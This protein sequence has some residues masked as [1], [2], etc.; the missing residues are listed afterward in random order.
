MVMITVAAMIVG[1]SG[2]VSRPDL[3]DRAEEI[4]DVLAPMPGVEKVETDY[5]VSD[6]GRTLRY[7]VTMTAEATDDEAA[8]LAS[9]LNSEVGPEFEDYNHEL[10]MMMS[11]FTLELPIET[12]AD[13]LRQQMP[14]LRVLA[15][16]LAASEVLWRE[17]P[18]NDNIED[19]LEIKSLSGNPFDAFSAVRDQFGTDAMSLRLEQT[20]KAM[21]YVKFPYSVPAQD[22]LEAALGSGLKE[23]DQIIVDSDQLTSVSAIVSEGPKVVSRLR[24]IIDLVNSSTSDPWSFDWSVEPSSTSKNK[25]K[26]NDLSTGGL[27]SVGGCDYDRHSAAEQDPSSYMTSEAIA[28]QNKLRGIYDKCL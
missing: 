14:H 3:S 27:V 28:V 21:W 16:S 18:D 9:T 10:T 24:R 5:L 13:A 17:F 6:S 7:R 26:N 25:T 4:G 22:G 15:S 23:M 19:T 2:C 11:G 1:L 8:K 12:A 20:S